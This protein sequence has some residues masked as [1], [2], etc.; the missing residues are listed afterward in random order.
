MSQP[1]SCVSV[2]QKSFIFQIDEHPEIHFDNKDVLNFSDFINLYNQYCDGCFEF[3][4]DDLTGFHYEPNLQ[5]FGRQCEN[6]MNLIIRQKN[7]EFN[8]SEYNVSAFSPYLDNFVDLFLEVQFNFK[9]D[10]VAEIMYDGKK[11]MLKYV[12]ETRDGTNSYL[13]EM[14]D[15]ES[16]QFSGYVMITYDRCNFFDQHVCV[17]HKQNEPALHLPQ[18]IV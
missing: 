10:I 4:V 9:R 12:N 15:I 16:Q 5:L 8:S 13:Y 18:I 7:A 2:P 6:L 14:T 1:L 3:H 11:H 17:V